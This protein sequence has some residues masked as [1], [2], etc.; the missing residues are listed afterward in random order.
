MTDSKTGMGPGL[1]SSMGQTV[2]QVVVVVVVVEEGDAL[3]R[4]GDFLRTAFFY[5]LP[6]AEQSAY[7]LTWLY[8]SSKVR[9]G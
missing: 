5:F 9:S 2:H 6:F 3:W 4:K 8:F 7:N 1:P